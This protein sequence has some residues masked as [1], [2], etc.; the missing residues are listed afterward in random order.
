M[1]DEKKGRKV[2]VGDLPKEE[3]KLSREEQ[4][5]VKG[6]AG[7]AVSMDLYGNKPAK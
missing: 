1:A 6:G 7:T 2:K 4:E 3:K 5:R